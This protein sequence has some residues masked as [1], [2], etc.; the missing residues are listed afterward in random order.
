[1]LRPVG[2]KVN[3]VSKIVPFRCKL[4]QHLLECSLAHLPPCN[5]SPFPLC[6]HWQGI[7]RDLSRAA[8]GLP[9]PASPSIALLGS[10]CARAHRDRNSWDI[11]INSINHE[12]HA[13]LW[14][15]WALNRGRV[16]TSVLRFPG[17][18]W[19][20]GLEGI[21]TP[22]FLL[23]GGF[24]LDSLLLFGFT[25]FVVIPQWFRHLKH[26]HAVGS[27][28]LRENNIVCGARRQHA[29]E[30]LPLVHHGVS[31]TIR[32]WCIRDKGFPGMA[33]PVGIGENCGVHTSW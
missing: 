21:P 26:L 2:P 4:L 10:A 7:C 27:R 1:M 14:L 8:G 9:T 19:F 13:L 25:H 17:L 12:I 30:L 24:L 28:G 3:R 15:F 11:H 33:G 6:A 16:S 18:F 31:T 5:P 32:D 23:R 29:V 22:S 20:W